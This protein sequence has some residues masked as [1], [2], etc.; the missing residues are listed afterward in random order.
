MEC[1][2]HSFQDIDSVRRPGE[3]SCTVI[4]GLV[5]R[6]HIRTDVLNEQGDAVDPFKLKPVLRMG[7][8]G[9]GKWLEGY[10]LERPTWPERKD[11]IEGF[12]GKLG[13]GGDGLNKL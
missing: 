10:L 5:K 12:Y 7:S 1:E 13:G 8:G 2:L 9:Y 4:I 11:E 3:R 6:I